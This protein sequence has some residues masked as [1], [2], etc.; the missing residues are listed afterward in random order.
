MGIGTLLTAPIAAVL[1]SFAITRASKASVNKEKE[2]RANVNNTVGYEQ[3]QKAE[4]S[5]N[6]VHKT[7]TMEKSQDKLYNIA[8]QH[9][10]VSLDLFLKEKFPGLSKWEPRSDKLLS[11]EIHKI[12]IIYESGV[13][14]KCTIKPIA[15][16]GCTKFAFIDGN[17][18]PPQ[19]PDTEEDD[20]PQPEPIVPEPESKPPE[21][22]SWLAT[23]MDWLK[24][25]EQICRQ[26]EEDFFIIDEKHSFADDDD[27]IKLSEQLS[28]Y[29]ML[30]GHED[31]IYTI[32]ISY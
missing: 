9:Y 2:E 24:E 28:Y 4:S 10:R 17:P 22:V 16:I 32:S 1:S 21:K 27:I 8:Y 26:N 11:D 23:H 7:E 15:A 5:E 19:K 6:E 12:T 3:N 13:R 30:L 14:H 18:L 25:Q 20:E 29:G 31:G